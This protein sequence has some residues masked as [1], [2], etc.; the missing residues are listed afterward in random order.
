MDAITPK[1]VKTDND[2]GVSLASAKEA[3]KLTTEPCNNDA[4]HSGVSISSNR[5]GFSQKILFELIAV[6][7]VHVSFSRNFAK[8]S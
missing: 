1:I 8:C 2:S 3:E 5:I 6:T 7:L 4:G